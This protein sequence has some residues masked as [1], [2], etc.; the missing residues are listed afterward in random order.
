MTRQSPLLKEPY[1]SIA[2]D[3]ARFVIKILEE[4]IN[5]IYNTVG[6]E[7]PMTMA[8]FLYGIRAVTSS[9]VQFTWVSADFLVEMDVGAM[10]D[11]PIW[12]LPRDD[13]A[14]PAP[15]PVSGEAKPRMTPKLWDTDFTA[16]PP[17]S[18]ATVRQ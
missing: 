7:A 1:I 5:G 6:P 9:P 4:D 13:Y 18:T 8:E 11:L 17:D 15:F 16:P 3:L 14:T 10:T 12:F 2:H